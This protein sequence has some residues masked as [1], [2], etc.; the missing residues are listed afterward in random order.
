MEE[1]KNILILF[2]PQRSGKDTAAYYISCKYGYRYFDISAPVKSIASDLYGDDVDRKHL[3]KIAEACREL[4]NVVWARQVFQSYFSLY[5]P[6]PCY[7]EESIPNAVISGVRHPEDILYLQHSFKESF[8]NVNVY[9]V[10]IQRETAAR[11]ST[12]GFSD[13]FKDHYTEHLLDF[14]DGDYTILNNYDKPFL[15][16]QL[17]YMLLDIE[18]KGRAV[19]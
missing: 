5:G 10:R 6:N 4:D 2:G 11:I 9:T 7:K 1:K 15:L 18:Q 13:E 12:T 3:I 19:K 14:Y 16:N 17:D 8:S